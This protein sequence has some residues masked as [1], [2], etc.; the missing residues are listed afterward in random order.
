MKIT[1]PKPQNRANIFEKNK[2]P[3]EVN[4]AR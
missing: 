3:N 1:S 2:K 4:S